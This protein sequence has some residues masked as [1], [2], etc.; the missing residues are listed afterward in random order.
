MWD[1]VVSIVI[2]NFY[3]VASILK[4][5]SQSKTAAGLQCFH[6]MGV[7]MRV[8]RRVHS[9]TSLLLGFEHNVPT[10][11]THNLL[12][13]LQ[14]VV[15]EAGK[16]LWACH[17]MGLNKMRIWTLRKGEWILYK[18]WTDFATEANWR[19]FISLKHISPLNFLFQQTITILPVS[20]KGWK[21]LHYCNAF[22]WPDTHIKQLPM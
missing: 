10:Y 16:Y 17:I 7:K 3:H 5:S 8:R 22:Q 2:R 14:P 11:I 12:T 1:G 4:D 19:H 9:Q 20:N 6:V 18:Q 15:Q 13:W 21:Y